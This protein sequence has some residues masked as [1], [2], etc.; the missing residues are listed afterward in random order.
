MLRPEV[1]HMFRSE[2]PMNFKLGT[3]MAHEDPYR[4]DGPS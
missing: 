1:L 4:R 3:Q 2:R